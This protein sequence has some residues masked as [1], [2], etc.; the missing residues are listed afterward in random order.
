MTER[1]L[2]D[3]RFSSLDL[4]PA[5]L[6]GIEDAGFEY[7]T[8]IQAQSLPAVLSGQDVEGQAQTGTGKT[9]AFLLAIMNVL[10]REPRPAGRRETAVNRARW[11]SRPR[12]SSRCRST[13]MPS[14]L[15]C[16]PGLRFGVVFGGTGY[17]S[18][19]ADAAF[20]GLDV[21][22]GTP[23]RLIDYLRA[24]GLPP[25]GGTGRGAR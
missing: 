20:D 14:S 19:R 4:E 11:C 22:V 16:I 9:A 1:L 23:G 25:E 7:C 13:A 12:A 10:L 2:T 21:L 24:G 18:Q 15:E 8:P 5:I 3:V 6:R 17:E